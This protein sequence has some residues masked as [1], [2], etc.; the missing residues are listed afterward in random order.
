MARIREDREEKALTRGMILEILQASVDRERGDEESIATY[1][2]EDVIVLKVGRRYPQTREMI[3]GHLYYM[4][5][6]GYVKF[7]EVRVGREKTLMWRITA[8][9]TDL[10]EGNKTDPGIHIE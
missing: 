8:N 4:Q 2:D 3:R 6:K 10:L 7:R 1:L 5:D 9:G